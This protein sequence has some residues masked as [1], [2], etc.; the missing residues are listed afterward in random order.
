MHDSYAFPASLTGPWRDFSSI[1]KFHHILYLKHR[2]SF[3]F[4]TYPHW[5]SGSGSGVKVGPLCPVQD[6]VEFQ[7]GRA[8]EL[9][10]S[11]GWMLPWSC[12][13]CLCPVSSWVSIVDFYLQVHSGIRCCGAMYA[14]CQWGWV[15]TVPSSMDQIAQTFSASFPTGAIF[16]SPTA[17]TPTA[18]NGDVRA[19]QTVW[20][21]DMQSEL[22]VTGA[23]CTHNSLLSSPPQSIVSNSK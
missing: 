21:S 18:Y 8:L 16:A 11:Q 17:V 20:K 15:F 19:Q 13:L 10:E 1:A 22:S 23:M 14:A 12:P 2:Q 5:K 9:L 6:L 3:A 4:F 7:T